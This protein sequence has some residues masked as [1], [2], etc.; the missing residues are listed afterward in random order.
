[1]AKSKSDAATNRG[2][3]GQALG[4]GPRATGGD[5]A[6][7]AIGFRPFFLFAALS[8]FL[9][10]PLWLAGLLLGVTWPSPLPG[11]LW[12]GHE[13]L[14]GYTSA[15]I[16]GFLLT[17]TQNWTGQVTARGGLLVALAA[18]WLAA[19]L[20]CTLG[21]SLPLVFT[22]AIDVSFLVSLALCVTRPIARTRNYRNAAMPILLLAF[23]SADALWWVGVV[24]LDA[25]SILRAQ[26]VAL[27]L[28]AL[29]IVVIGGRIIPGFTANATPGL[30]TRSRN[31]VDVVGVLSMA[32]LLAVDAIA[33]RGEA[34]GYCAV[35]AAA[36]NAARL[37][38]WG[39]SHTLRSPILA[40]L[41]IGFACTCAA[42]ALR[43]YANL[44]SAML[45]STAT[46]LLTVAGI[47]LMT[48]GMMARVALGHTGR[49]LVLPRSIVV[50][51]AAIGASA[52]IRVLG[53]LIVPGHYSAV[54]LVSGGLWT[55]AFTLFLAHYAPILVA[56]RVDGKPG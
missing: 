22:A 2:R 41:H 55:F 7:W 6:L 48:L 11:P 40:V 13:M 1:M 43:A 45:E 39:G 20:L 50:A 37:W 29:L 15:V 38:G 5:V 56:P 9:L 44:T 19:R 35:L 12:H 17:A 4:Q 10:V 18:L 34:A 23:A 53:P 30:T 16:A 28:I 21:G 26:R 14:F 24:Q 51:I 36:L 32:V 47:G 46:H 52:L 33:P 31:A 27:D 8:A 25:L 3:H 42:L 54:L 49:P